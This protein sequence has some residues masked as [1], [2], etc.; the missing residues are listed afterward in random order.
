MPTLQH[1]IPVYTGMTSIRHSGPRDGIY[2]HP[3]IPAKA[4]I[5]HYPVIPANAGIQ[6]LPV[7]PANAGIHGLIF[8]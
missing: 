3:V 8:K 2:Q 1:W 7:I 6:H 4:R 5:Q